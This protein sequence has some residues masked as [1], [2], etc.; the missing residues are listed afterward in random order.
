MRMATRLIILAAVLVLLIASTQAVTIDWVT[1]GN[2][3][4]E[5]DTR[6]SDFNHR[7]GFGEVDYTYRI[8]KYEVTAGQYTE[9]LN[10][11]A[12]DDIFGLYN[13]MMDYDANPLRL[14]ANIKRTGSAPNFSYSI[15]PDWANR[16]VN[17][18]NIWDAARFANWLHNGQ[19]TGMQGPGTTE[20]GAYTNIG[21][22]ATFARQS[23]AKFWIPSLDEWYKAAY[24]DPHH[25]GPGIG[26]YWDY[27]TGSNSEPGRDLTESTNTGNNANYFVSGSGPS[28]GSLL[29]GPY[30]R[31]EVGQFHLSDSPYGTFDQGG[32][33]LEWNETAVTS[34]VQIARG[35]SFNSFSS[36]MRPGY[37]LNNGG[38]LEVEMDYMGFRVASL[39][40]PEPSSFILFAMGLVT[41]ACR[42]RL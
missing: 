24:Y 15:A 11:V 2:P 9:F 33:V 40:I 7:D 27:P 41:A 23:G 21:N 36:Y 17:Y 1:V 35:G 19:P 29:G 31:T 30:H 8:G 6:Y 42:P 5:V 13:P 16:P 3:G 28:K 32:N 12:A 26:G 18:V 10:A 14:G 22:A 4:N 25:G 39:A 20:D 37:F 38:G 34:S